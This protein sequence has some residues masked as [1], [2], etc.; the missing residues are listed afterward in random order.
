MRASLSTLWYHY[1]V[2]MFP[3]C[4]K[5]ADYNK[6]SKKVGREVQSAAM[7]LIEW[8]ACKKPTALP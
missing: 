8:E 3:C 2:G 4:R 6:G 7:G 1:A 5:V